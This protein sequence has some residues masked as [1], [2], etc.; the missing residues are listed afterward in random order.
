MTTQPSGLREHKK[1]QTRQAISDVATGLFLERGFEAVTIADIAAAAQVAKMTVTNYFP[2]KEDL[3]LD[4]QEAFIGSLART[5]ADRADGESALTAL[6]RAFFDAVKDQDPVIG[7][8]GLAFVRMIV[9]S[10]AL[11]ARLRDF[12]DLRE[13]ALADLLTTETDAT[14]DDIT[15]RAVAAQL[16]AAHRVLFTETIRHTLDGDS[17][18]QIAAALTQAGTQTFDLLTPA[19]ADYAVRHARDTT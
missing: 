10:P 13:Q 16:G 3:A 19:L 12:H 5:V 1:Q 11:T 6:R 2:R 7:F 9:D 18:D 8:A 15:P 14:A 17:P 4:L